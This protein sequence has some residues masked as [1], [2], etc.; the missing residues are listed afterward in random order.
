MTNVKKLMRVDS[1]QQRYYQQCHYDWDPYSNTA[2]V[3][4]VA[5]VDTVL[6]VVDAVVVVVVVGRRVSV[7][8]V[9]LVVSLLVIQ[10]APQT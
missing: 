2:S 1:D 5:V 4:I 3:G 6:A 7:A 10:S 8:V 9:E